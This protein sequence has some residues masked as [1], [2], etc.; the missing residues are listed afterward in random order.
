MRK[1]R[2][3]TKEISAAELVADSK[4][5]N[6]LLVEG[7]VTTRRLVVRIGRF[8]ARTSGVVGLSAKCLDVLSISA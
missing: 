8:D 7:L 2:D 1:I 5:I 4:H 6:A 3:R